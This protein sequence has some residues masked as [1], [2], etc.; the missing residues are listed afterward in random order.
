MQSRTP[1][2]RA[3]VP[4]D[5]LME[6]GQKTDPELDGPLEISGH[7]PVSPRA[8]RGGDKVRFAEIGVPRALATLSPPLVGISGWAHYA[9]PK[10]RRNP[11]VYT[12][13]GVKLRSDPWPLDQT[14]HRS[15]RAKW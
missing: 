1:A 12:I 10:G 3:K 5:E 14:I 2:G 9:S 7:L 13:L 4:L 15:L 8:A 6:V 11:I